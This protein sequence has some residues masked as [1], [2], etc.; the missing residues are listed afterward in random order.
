[1]LGRRRLNW[2]A[3]KFKPRRSGKAKVKK[4]GVVKIDVE[5]GLKLLAKVEKAAE[6]NKDQV[7]LKELGALREWLEELAGE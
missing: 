5:P 3:L 2:P 1:M 4:A 6:L 7:I